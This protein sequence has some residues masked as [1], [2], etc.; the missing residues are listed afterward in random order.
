MF[1]IVVEEGSICVVVWCL[2]VLLVV[3][4]KVVKELEIVFGVLFVVCIVC[5]V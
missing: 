3:L 2:N 5:G 4:M 1:V